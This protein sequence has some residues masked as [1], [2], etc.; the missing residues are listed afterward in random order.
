MTDDPRIAT[1]VAKYTREGVAGNPPINFGNEFLFY[2]GRDDVH[3]VLLELLSQEKLSLKLN[4]FG[5]DDEDLNTAILTLCKDPAIH[6]QVSL[7]KSQSAG[8]HEKTLIT[9][10]QQNDA[11]EFAN[12]FLIL[13]SATNQISHTKGGVLA[14]QGI[15]FEGST[16]WSASGEGSGINLKD[17]NANPKG[18]KAQNNTLLVSTNPVNLSRFATELDVEHQI[19]LQKQLKGVKNATS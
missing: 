15:Y 11:T 18:W 8:V 4:M 1:L 7:D 14:S 9:F 17:A 2:V 12:S 5:Y 10:D 19:G 13:E 6:V 3:G 16:N